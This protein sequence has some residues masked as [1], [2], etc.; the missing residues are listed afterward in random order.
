MARTYKEK[1]GWRTEGQGV[2]V[3]AESL[4]ECIIKFLKLL[5]FKDEI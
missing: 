1:N 5:G 2:T 4:K 3:W